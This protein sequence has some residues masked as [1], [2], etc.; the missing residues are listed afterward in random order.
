MDKVLADT[1]AWIEFFR[2]REPWHGVVA[3]LM[4]DRRL[5]CM[6][7]ILAELIQGAKSDAERDVLR[8]FVHVFEFLPDTVD[9]WR[10]AG[11]L[12]RAFRK[13][14]K[15][16]GLADCHIAVTAAVGN[17]KLLTLDKHFEVLKGA[18]GLRLF[19]LDERVPKRLL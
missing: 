8:D 19:E 6:G 7:I 3:T 10:Q 9:H 1:S 17:V 5:C 15:S 12:S 2:K 14:G 11:E 4:D 16:I 13:K 18:A